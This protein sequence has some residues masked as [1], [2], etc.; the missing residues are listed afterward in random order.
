MYMEPKTEKL[1]KARSEDNVFDEMLMQTD[2]V[3]D[4]ELIA[5]TGLEDLS[6]YPLDSLK[7]E[8]L[9]ITFDEPIQD[10]FD[11]LRATTQNYVGN[12][13]P[14]Q[15]A[16]VDENT[17]VTELHEEYNRLKNKDFVEG[18]LKLEGDDEL[19]KCASP[20]RYAL[21]RMI[22]DVLLSR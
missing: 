20:L 12:I 7:D 4:D 13:S 21:C 1:L 10:P 2:E 14:N 11:H 6:N 5:S 9:V 17:I 18:G 8:I 16:V 15:F 3:Q 22:Y 19:V